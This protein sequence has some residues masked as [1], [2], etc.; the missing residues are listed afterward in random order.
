MLTRG[1]RPRPGECIA[2]V[3]T[4]LS[5]AAGHQTLLPTVTLVFLVYNRREELR[6]SLEKMLVESDYDAD[7][8]DVVVV[9]NASNDG[10]SEMVTAEFPHV[11]LLQRSTNSG[12]SGFND[13]F[14]VAGGDWVLA[15]DGRLVERG[16]VKDQVIA[17]VQP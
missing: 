13:G 10:S 4:A 3:E 6:T 5:E 15:L 11:R 17:V 1:R 7:R 2:Q 12:V 16:F 14:A 8:L 9:D